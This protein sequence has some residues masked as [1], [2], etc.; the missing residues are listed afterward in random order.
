[1]EREK[2]VYNFALALVNK[3]NDKPLAKCDAYQIW[4]SCH[5]TDAIRNS[6]SEST[7]VFHFGRKTKH[8]VKM[9]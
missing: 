7:K 8:S 1:M 6:Q 5:N 2:K 4:K 3:G 9:R